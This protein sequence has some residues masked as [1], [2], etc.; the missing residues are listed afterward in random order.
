LLD[1]RDAVRAAGNDSEDSVRSRYET[2]R[3]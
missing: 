2:V 1:T 3:V